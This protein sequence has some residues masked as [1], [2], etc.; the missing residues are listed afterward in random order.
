[1]EAWQAVLLA[2]GALLVGALVPTLGILALA[3]AQ[4]R[5]AVHQAERVLAAAAGTVERIDRLTSRL[6][7]RGGMDRLVKGIDGLTRV[8]A[9][10]EGG[11]RVASALGAAVGPAVGAAVRSWRATAAEGDGAGPGGLRPAG[12]ELR[13]G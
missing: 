7:E 12:G 1:M 4:V 10:L 11:T 8:V 9:S 2:V 13:D 6:E 5:G 3:L